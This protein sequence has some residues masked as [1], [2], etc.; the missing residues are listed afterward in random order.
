MEKSTNSINEQ[1]SENSSF[2]IENLAYLVYRAKCN[3]LPKPIVFLGAGASKSA[4]IPIADEIIEDVKRKFEDKPSVK[5]LIRLNET[6]YYKVMQALT[7][8]ERRDL[9]YGYISDEKVKI[10]LTNIYLA[11]LLQ[12]R[13]I[14]VHSKSKAFQKLIFFQKDLH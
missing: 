5:E 1:I 10:N 7:S 3:N 13:L 8:D 9:F 14:G 12:M 4:G 2:H 11:Q 6:D